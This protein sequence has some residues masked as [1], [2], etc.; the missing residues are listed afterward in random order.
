MPT[1]LQ[2]SDCHLFADPAAEIRGVRTRETF[3]RVWDHACRSFPQADRL[4]LS[5]D[6]THDE[7]IE[8]YRELHSIVADWLPRLLVIPGNHDDRSLLREV[9]RSPRVPGLERIVFV[10]HLPG[11]QLIGSLCCT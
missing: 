9:F 4:V 5:G 6:L 8:T 7:R 2:I 3:L 1:I 10:E 11:W